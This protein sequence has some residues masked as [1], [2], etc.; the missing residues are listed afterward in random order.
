[1]IRR[2]AP[3]STLLYCLSVKLIGLIQVRDTAAFSL[4]REQVAATVERYNGRVL[5]RG[6]QT[7]M[8]WN[9]LDCPP[10]DFLVE[11]SFPSAQDAQRWADSPEYRALLSVRSQAMRLT[12][13]CVE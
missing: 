7:T 8:L 1:M 2:H 5:G 6:R 3:S 11:L 13:F 12:L 4:Y 9:E 10:F